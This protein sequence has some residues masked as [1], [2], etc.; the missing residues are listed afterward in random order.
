VKPLQINRKVEMLSY[1]TVSANSKTVTK[2]WVVLDAKDQVLGRFASQAALIIRGKTKANY[3]PHVDCGDNVIIINADKIK[4]TGRKWTQREYIS[5]T[6]Y[7]G[8]QRFI[9][10]AK[11]MAKNPTMVVE[12]SIHGMLPKNRLGNALKGNVYIYAGSEHPHG[13]QQPKTINLK[14]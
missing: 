7:P 13:A 6:G 8:G 3:T 4:L 10:P 2:D 5:H 11:L 14:Y 9:T 12:K 1:K